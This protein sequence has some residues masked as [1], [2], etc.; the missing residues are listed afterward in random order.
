MEQDEQLQRWEDE[1][2]NIADQS[3]HHEFAQ[4]NQYALSE[5]QKVGR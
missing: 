4:S 1:G 5:G 2:G 3:N